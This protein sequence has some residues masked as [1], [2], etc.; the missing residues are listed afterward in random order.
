MGQ[1]N[2]TPAGMFP[3]ESVVIV[4]GDVVTGLPSNV[5]LTIDDDAKPLK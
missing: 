4:M 3:D 5:I 1:V 2:V